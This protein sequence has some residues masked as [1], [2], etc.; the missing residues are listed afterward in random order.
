MYRNL[1]YRR[2]FSDGPTTH[3]VSI[4][5]TWR[6]ITWE[7]ALQELYSNLGIPRKRPP[8]IRIGT[9]SSSRRR[10]L[11]STPSLSRSMTKPTTVPRPE[12][13]STTTIS[14]HSWWPMHPS[15]SEKQI[16]RIRIRLLQHLKERNASWQWPGLVDLW[17]DPINASW[18][19]EWSRGRQSRIG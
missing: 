17:P 4:A 12:K 8:S 15:T 5:S 9:I 14:L 1:K 2:N 3:L 19:E 6:C 7:R 16:R 10:G 11:G 18:E 13:Y